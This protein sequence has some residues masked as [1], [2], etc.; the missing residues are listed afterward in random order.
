MPDNDLDHSL[1]SVEAQIAATNSADKFFDLPNGSRIQFTFRTD[2]LQG[3]QRGSKKVLAVEWQVDYQ[4][5][6]KSGNKVIEGY[7][8]NLI[9]QFQKFAREE[10]SPG[11]ILIN[12]PEG[13]FTN[14][15]KAF[16]NT[17]SADQRRIIKQLNLL[18]KE[19]PEVKEKWINRAFNDQVTEKREILKKNGNSMTAVDKYNAS[20]KFNLWK[21]Y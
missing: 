16:N 3:Y 18:L 4:T 12:H 11:T 8:R 20:S 15:S 5:K 14:I 7:G 21:I 1:A 19:N 10:L 13:D 6:I 9:T 17:G 2:N